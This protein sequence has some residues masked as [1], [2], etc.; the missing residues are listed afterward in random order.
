MPASS[1]RLDSERAAYAAERINQ[2]SMTGET[3]KKYRSAVNNA[4]A[5]L[6]QCGLLQLAAFYGSGENRKPVWDD[7]WAW[8]TRASTTTALLNA[9]RNHLSL[10]DQ[11]KALSGLSSQELALLERESEEILGWLKRL[12]EAKHQEEERKKAEGQNKE[13]DQARNGLAAQG[14][15]E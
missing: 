8:L 7:L 3:L 1:G 5:Y 13:N 14:E 2:G 4:P 9:V 6:R 10:G 15:G 12:T 11:M